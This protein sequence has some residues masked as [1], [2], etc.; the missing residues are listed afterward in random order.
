MLSFARTRSQDSLQVIEG[1]DITL[2][3]PLDNPSGEAIAWLKGAA[4]Y[5]TNA[6]RWTAPTRF[7]VVSRGTVYDLILTGALREDDAEFICQAQQDA[8][9]THSIVLTILVPPTQPTITTN[10]NVPAEG[11]TIEFRC[12]SSQG[13]PAPDVRWYRNDQLLDGGNLV[14]PTVKYGETY[15]VLERTLS[16]DD[17]Q[18]TYGCD[19][20]N[21]ANQNTSP[22]LTTVVLNV[23]YAP[24]ITFNKENPYRVTRGRRLEISCLVDANPVYSQVFWVTADGS[25]N[26][27]SSPV[28]VFESVNKDHSGAYRCEAQNS[29]DIGQ[30]I[31]QLDVQYQ[32]EVTILINGEPKSDDELVQVSEN[33]SVTITCQTDANPP[34]DEAVTWYYD[35]QEIH[36]GNTLE[37]QPITRQQTGS[38]LCVARNVL[39]PSEGE[40]RLETG[41]ATVQIQVQYRPGEARVSGPR[42]AIKGEYATLR[43][44]VTDPGE[45]SATLR[46]SLAPASGG[47]AQQPVL[48]EG[49]EFAFS[50]VSL[51][52]EGRYVCLPTNAVGDGWPGYYNLTVNERPEWVPVDGQVG[53]P[54][55]L[56]VNKTSTNLQVT[57]RARGRPEPEITWYKDGRPINID[58][59]HYT[60]ETTGEMVDRISYMVTST[61]H[62]RGHQRPV[63]SSLQI[64]DG[65]TYSCE[66]TN[67]VAI[68]TLESEMELIVQYAPVL[69]VSADKVAID[70]NQSAILECTSHS[71]PE[72]TFE[73]YKDNNRLLDG[74]RLTIRETGS[75]EEFS[76]QSLLDISNVNELD[77][78][79]YTCLGKNQ[80]GSN[81][82]TIDLTVKTTPDPPETLE[83]V[84]RTWESQELR[85]VPGFDGG[86][87]QWFILDFHSEMH[88]ERLEVKPSNAV[89]YNVTGL[90]PSTNYTFRVYGVNELGSGGYSPNISGITNS[91]IIEPPTKVYYNEQHQTLTFQSP[92]TNYCV[93]IETFNGQSW[94]VYEPC[95][96]A[97][98]GSIKLHKDS[99]E[100]VR[101]KLCLQR[102]QV[103]CSLAA[104]AEIGL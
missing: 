8:Q 6:A 20:I 94:E 58:E 87:P 14:Q 65:A 79:Q 16:R 34:I 46:W 37:Y 71:L 104:R 48:L 25:Q 61:L 11:D 1:G 96:S 33:E 35:G 88:S 55:Q 5:F 78:G 51:N 102:R 75:V 82:V 57:C 47:V 90:L 49:P 70:I 27:G 68:R 62:W 103:V 89:K 97:I 13:N 100:D 12:S 24:I 26:L 99:I 42:Q 83:V 41:E 23:R 18:A 73:W 72:T 17:H 38:Y 40:T 43:C 50:P 44:Q 95:A 59:G 54:S 28:L 92:S 93:H 56:T 63:M 4:L 45:P 36:R 80:L 30:G 39:S 67:P 76:H 81:F 15:S 98:G 66:I 19:A 10:N 29:V 31:L 7:D 74:D 22:Q 101:V 91:F 21:E 9:Q 69:N 85:W 77:L 53:I 2:A 32:P 86:Y 3:C 60:V 64:D 84:S 52:D